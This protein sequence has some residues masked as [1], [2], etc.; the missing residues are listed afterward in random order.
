MHDE[1]NVGFA[2]AV[3]DGLV[4]ANAR[5]VDQLDLT[6]LNQETSRLISMIESGQFTMKLLWMLSQKVQKMLAL[7]LEAEKKK[8]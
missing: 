4:V 6:A 3:G 7:F 5:N 8:P 2:V 1:I